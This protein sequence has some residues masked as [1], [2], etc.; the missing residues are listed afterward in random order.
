MNTRHIIFIS[1]A[2]GLMGCVSSEKQFKP[3]VESLQQY[4]TPEWF[5]DAK[6][7][8]WNVWGPYSVPEVG[9]WYAR[10]MY[11]MESEKTWQ[12]QGPYHRKVWGHQSKIGY[13]DFIPMW[14]AEKFDANT[15]MEQYKKAGA[16]YY[17]SIA[18]FH[19]NYDLFDSKHTRWNSVKTG[20]KMDMVKAFQEAAHAQGLRYGATTHLARSLDWWTVNKG[21]SE[22]PYDG[23]DTAYSDLYHPYYDSKNPNHKYIADEWAT[24]WNKRIKDLI[25]NY[26]LDLLY[27]DGF[28]PFEEKGYDVVSHFYNNNLQRHNGTENGVMCIKG[29]PTEAGKEY[30]EVALMDYERKKSGELKVNAWQTDDHMGCWGYNQYANYR[31]TNYIVDKLIDIVSKNGN[32]LLCLPLKADGTHPEAIDTFL[33][34]MAE[35]MELNG[36]AIY[37]TRP[38]KIFGEGPLRKEAKDHGDMANEEMMNEKDIRFTTKGNNLYAFQLGWPEN[39]TMAIRALGTKSEYNSKKIS[40]VTMVGSNEKLDFDQNDE[41]LLVKLPTEHHCKH[42]FV[43]NITFK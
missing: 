31:S 30:P 19:D 8:I 40:S 42:A 21:T 22:E 20:P 12:V 32:L 39:E 28:I 35:W 3:S 2:L 16:K 34:E 17:T 26:E 7:G 9:E 27:F 24:M 36:E 33:V 11:I 37:G 38:W 6:F 23:V 1:I 13:K 41:Q 43:V 15:L 10:N 5:R 14:K 29:W 25:D 4:E 18:T